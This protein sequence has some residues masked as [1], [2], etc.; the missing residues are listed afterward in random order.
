MSPRRLIIH[1]T[2]GLLHG[3]GLFRWLHRRRLPD[4]ISVVMY[5]G[6]LRAPLPVADWCFLQVDRFAAQMEYLTRHFRVMH[7]EEALDPGVRGPTDP[8]LA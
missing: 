6:L 7:L 4:A 3:L 1:R 2:G 5:H 8:S